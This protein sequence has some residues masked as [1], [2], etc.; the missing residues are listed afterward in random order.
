[1]EKISVIV[2]VYNIEDYIGRC[3]E[4]ILRQTWRNLE[5]ILVDDGS[6]DRSGSICDAYAA[7]DHR[8]KVI[9]QQNKGLSGA[10]NSG[11]EI[12]T[13]EYIGFVDGDDW[14][15]K[16]MYEF[17][18]GLLEENGADI[19][20]CGYT[21]QG[22]RTES[23]EAE[24]ERQTAVYGKR[25]AV[26]TIVEDRKIHSYVWNKLY[27]RKL[28]AEVR[29]PEG[30]GMEDIAT[31]YKV[32][33][34]SGKVA[35]SDKPKYCYYQREG[36]IS[37]SWDEKLNWDLFSAYLERMGVL[38]TDYPE[39]R[40]F[41]VVSL[42]RFSVTAYNRLLIWGGQKEHEAVHKRIILDTMCKFR[43]ELTKLS[44]YRGLKLRLF[45]VCGSIYPH[46]YGRLKRL[47]CRDLKKI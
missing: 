26:R 29:F 39:L 14:I 4:S 9:H 34:L 6:S 28:F 40:E 32:F 35:V 24:A 8:I 19:A 23:R 17:L 20:V 10:R 27:R 47:L 25:E 31:T 21:V 16:D 30:R 13:G 42:L 38:E 11:L 45:V 2:P 5:I 15:L 33:M 7:E 41:L 22:G 43:K 46:V 1:M 12:C 36:S 44:G 37:R 3:I 18:Y